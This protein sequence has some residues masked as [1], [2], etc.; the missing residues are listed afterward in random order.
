MATQ[1]VTYL[2]QPALHP[3]R[4]DSHAGI[5]ATPE[6]A[7][8]AALYWANQ[9]PFV[10]TVPRSKAPVWAIEEAEAAHA[11]DEAEAEDLNLR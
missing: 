6:E 1:F 11:A 4:A 3:N 5:G 9:R 8:A 2:V 7:E 10:K